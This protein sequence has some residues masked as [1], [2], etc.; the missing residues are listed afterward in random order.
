[1]GIYDPPRRETTP[2]IAE[3]SSAG[4]K[5]HMLTGDHPATATAIAKEIGIIPRDLGV[6]PGDVAQS[7]AMKAFEFDRMTDA[8]ID[9]LPE[10][11]LVLARC[12]PDTKTRM[13]EA[14]R[15]RRAFMAMTGDGVNDAPSLSSADVGI[16]MV[17]CTSLSMP[18]FVRT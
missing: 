9:A 16:A 14:L 8:E 12:A 15:R 4:I 7:V 1:V 6:L 13:I 2:A 18:N 10:L 3:C 5:V 11:P 17:S